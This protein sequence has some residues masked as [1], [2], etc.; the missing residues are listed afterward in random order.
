VTIA[1][2]LASAT[3]IA[4]EFLLHLADQRHRTAEA[5]EAEA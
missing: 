3:A 2:R 5:K 1:E 4:D